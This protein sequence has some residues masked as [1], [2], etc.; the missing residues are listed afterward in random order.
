MKEVKKSLSIIYIG[1]GARKGSIGKP[2]KSRHGH[3]TVKRSIL[4]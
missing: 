3:A 4:I 2:V 1:A